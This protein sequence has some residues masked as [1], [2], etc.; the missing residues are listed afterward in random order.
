MKSDS[1]QMSSWLLSSPNVVISALIAQISWALLLQEAW[2][3]L[4]KHHAISHVLTSRCCHGRR[5][6]GTSG[7]LEKWPGQP[8][9]AVLKMVSG[10]AIPVLGRTDAA[11]TTWGR[12]RPGDGSWWSFT[13]VEYKRQDGG[14]DCGRNLFPW[15]YLVMK[16]CLW[17]SMCDR[18]WGHRNPISP[19]G[20]MSVVHLQ[21]E[22]E[23][24]TNPCQ[25]LTGNLAGWK[26]LFGGCRLGGHLVAYSELL[27]GYSAC[28]RRSWLTCIVFSCSL[29]ISFCTFQH[30]K[31]PACLHGMTSAFDSLASRAAVLD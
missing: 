23:R 10:Q 3:H 4:L 22:M 18:P 17:P 6:G 2:L 21:W 30:S 19:P 7:L 1:C 24:I 9:F 26:V 12:E 14:C 5:L 31:L 11:G 16:Q 25:R 27:V 28:S 29:P 8:Y 20:S 13:W 15:Q